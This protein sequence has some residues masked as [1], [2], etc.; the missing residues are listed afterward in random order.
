MNNITQTYACISREM[1]D[2]EWGGNLFNILQL[3]A[4]VELEEPM[5]SDL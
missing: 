3:L 1:C 5:S 2:S 4:E